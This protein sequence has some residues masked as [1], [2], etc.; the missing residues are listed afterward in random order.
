MCGV[1]ALRSSGVGALRSSETAALWPQA[2]RA[3]VLPD[4]DE[5]LPQG[6]HIGPIACVAGG[7]GLELG[8]N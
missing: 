8:V 1:G 7:V 5:G 2:V 3:A 6:F 4:Y